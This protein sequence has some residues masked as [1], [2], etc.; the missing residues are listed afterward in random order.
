ME[1]LKASAKVFLEDMESITD[2]AVKQSVGT[3]DQVASLDAE[4]LDM[5]NKINKLMKSFTD[6]V[7]TESRIIDEINSKLDKISAKEKHI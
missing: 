1:T 2:L 7:E 5:Y 4:T 6:Y 3:L